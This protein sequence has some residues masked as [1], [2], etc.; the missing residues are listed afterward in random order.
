MVLYK[1]HGKVV[2]KENIKEENK[3]AIIDKVINNIMGTKPIMNDVSSKFMKIVI[4]G[5]CPKCNKKGLTLS[6]KT[7]TCPFC[8]W[9]GKVK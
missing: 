6:K 3:M 8:K 9:E 5:P 7:Y 4:G 2:K 1:I